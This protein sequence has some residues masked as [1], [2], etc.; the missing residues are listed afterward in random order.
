[1][2]L[3]YISAWKTFLLT[4]AAT[5]P[6]SRKKENSYK[7]EILP[8]FKSNKEWMELNLLLIYGWLITKL[9]TNLLESEYVVYRLLKF[10]FCTN[11]GA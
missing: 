4:A 9:V 11:E 6:S 1:M 8:N 2:I 5:Y 7:L 3:Y 10:L